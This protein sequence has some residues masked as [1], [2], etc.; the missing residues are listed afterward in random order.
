MPGLVTTIRAEF[1]ANV[2]RTQ[3]EAKVIA[4]LTRVEPTPFNGLSRVGS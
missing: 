1:T 4:F 2:Q 3:L